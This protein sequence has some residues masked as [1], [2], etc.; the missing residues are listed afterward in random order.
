MSALPGL[1]AA[2]AAGVLLGIAVFAGLWLTV[3]RLDRARHPA[4]RVLASGLLRLGLLLAAMYALVVYGSWPEVLAAACGLTVA[5]F[6]VV[7]VTGIEPMRQRF[8][9]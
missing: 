5:R 2:F 8:D 7:R 9:A 3:R 6:A 4:L 1:L